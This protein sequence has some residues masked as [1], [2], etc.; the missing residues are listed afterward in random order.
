MEASIGK[1]VLHDHVHPI[2]LLHVDPHQQGLF[3]RPPFLT[4]RNTQYPD[5]RILLQLFPF[6]H[7]HHHPRELRR[8][9]QRD[10]SNRMFFAERRLR[11]HH[12]TRFISTQNPHAVGRNV[13]QLDHVLRSI[14]IPF[15][16]LHIPF[17][18]KNI[19]SI[20]QPPAGSHARSPQRDAHTT[21][22]RRVR[23]KL[24]RREQRPQL[25]RHCRQTARTAHQKHAVD[26]SR[27]QRRLA[28]RQHLAD[29]RHRLLHDGLRDHRQ[30]RLREHV[31]VLAAVLELRE[32]IDRRL[33]QHLFLRFLAGDLQVQRLS[34]T[35]GAVARLQVALHF[36]DQRHIDVLPAQVRVTLRLHHR[37]LVALATHHR[38][39]EG[40]ASEVVHE[41]V[42]DAC[43]LLVEFLGE[44]NCCCCR[45]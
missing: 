29:H 2:V 1:L 28:R 32:D 11:G 4:D 26:I 15:P 3:L 6:S 39:V 35:D 5:N 43:A 18:G 13:P 27:R 7:R 10:Q 45:L 16:I 24:L 37:V 41:V 20:P 31:T 40:A 30:R 21:Q 22:L 38:R 33:R 42:P 34:R 23:A 14:P 12:R 36:S 25:L 17:H 9:H 44:R 19:P 8:L